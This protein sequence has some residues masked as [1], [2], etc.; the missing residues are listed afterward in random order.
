M[1]P[2]S[3]LLFASLQLGA[4]AFTFGPCASRPA[5]RR[6]TIVAVEKVPLTA[7]AV[8]EVPLRWSSPSKS[9]PAPSLPYVTPGGRFTAA[10]MSSLEHQFA[11]ARLRMEKDAAAAAAA[12]D[13]I[14][15]ERTARTLQHALT[16][17]RAAL[18]KTRRE[19]VSTRATLEHELQLS[20]WTLIYEALRRDT[21]DVVRPL[22]ERLHDFKGVAL[23]YLA[24]LRVRFKVRLA[25]PLVKA[26]LAARKRARAWGSKTAESA[27]RGLRAWGVLYR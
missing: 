22:A 25:G 20:T 4:C 6:L 24:V 9:R 18:Q 23:L 16:T 7:S 21:V 27:R 26:A 1:L 13:A 17:S 12:C 3:A 19:L 8:E 15:A 2:M 5:I 10:D 11:V 14:E